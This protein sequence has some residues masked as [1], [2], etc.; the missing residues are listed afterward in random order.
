MA[1]YVKYEGIEGD[2]THEAHK[3][4]VD[5]NSMQFGVGRT[6]ST[7]TGRAS[8]R[9]ASSPAI[10]EITLT[11]DLDKSSTKWFQE[12]VSGSKGKAVQIDLV[13]TGN[14]GETYMTY[15]LENV[16]VSGYSI[17]ANGSGRPTETISLNFTKIEIAYTARDTDNTG[18]AANRGSYDLAT[19][20]SG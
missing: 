9:E 19:A 8:N 11:R 15:K 17:A 7:P 12:S 2:V 13:A 20:K 4:W 16:L 3:K 6:I 5:V 10:S 1:I 18:A 14:P